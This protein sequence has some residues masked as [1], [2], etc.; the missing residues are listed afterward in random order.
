MSDTP[1]VVPPVGGTPPVPVGPG[2]TGEGSGTPPP[3]SVS[4]ETHRQLLDEK[5]KSDARLRQ[6]EDEKA[7]RER[8]DLESRG[9]FEK[10]LAQERERSAELAAKLGLV[11][12]RE[13]G[14]RKLASVLSALNGHVESKYF[15]L[16]PI[17]DVIV[18]PTSGEVDQTS[19]ARVVEKV[20][21][22][23]P[24]IIK[25]KTGP[26]L[27]SA[28]PQGGA[29]PAGKIKSSDWRKLPAA[30]MRKWKPDQVIPD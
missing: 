20:R 8:K 7:E 3:S 22:N 19:V 21:A 23:Y 24:E 1:P 14:R 15:D 17:G 10:L 13:T 2:S 25:A 27:P 12:E 26:G 9:D 5:K 29:T 11:E 28:A 18:D 4:Y 6:L 16:I 30:E